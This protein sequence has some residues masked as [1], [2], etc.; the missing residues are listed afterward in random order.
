M[1]TNNKCCFYGSKF[2]SLVNSEL[3]PISIFYSQTNFTVYGIYM[4]EIKKPMLK[5]Y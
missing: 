4:L 2:S 3:Y 1:Y 5:K